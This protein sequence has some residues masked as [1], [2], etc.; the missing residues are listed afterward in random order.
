[1]TNPESVRGARAAVS[2]QTPASVATTAWQTPEHA[3]GQKTEDR[4]FL[5]IFGFLLIYFTNGF[6]EA[7][8]NH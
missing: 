3:K 8:A 5:A 4:K 7:S 6:L 1:V 2:A